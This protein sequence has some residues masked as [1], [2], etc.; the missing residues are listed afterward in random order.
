LTNK[1]LDANILFIL[2]Y[3][4]ATYFIGLGIAIYYK[5]NSYYLVGILLLITTFFL[6]IL[7]Y[8]YKNA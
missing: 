7:C 1:R 2:L 6:Q 4:L 3:F 8:T 5:L